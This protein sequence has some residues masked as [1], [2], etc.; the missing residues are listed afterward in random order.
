MKTLK[1]S[2]LSVILGLWFGF[3]FAQSECKV[4][5]PEIELIYKGECKNG[6][7]HGRGEATGRDHYVGDFK[8]GLP[9]GEGT[10]EWNS[11]EVYEGSWKK[12]MRHGMGTYLFF[13]NDR[14]S[15]LDGKWIKDEFVGQQS[16]SRS[17]TVEYTNNVGRTSFSKLGNAP[18][19]VRIRFMRSGGEMLVGNLTMQGSSGV[20]QMERQFVG[21]EMVEF[22]FKCRVT[23]TAPS[24]W[25]ASSMNCEIRFTINEP[26][27]WQ[28]NV[29]F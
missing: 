10:Y 14:D 15:I 3:G 4:L 25:H 20:E 12:G 16:Q 11:G 29:S 17:Y 18:P 6:L 28:V 8:K 13:V 23:F 26:G 9:H 1:R 24:T 22:P 21:F 19:Y 2:I 5:V 27:T 7:A